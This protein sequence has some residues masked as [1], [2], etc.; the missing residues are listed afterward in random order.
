[1]VEE[2]LEKFKLKLIRRQN[3]GIQIT[4]LEEDWRKAVIELLY[5]YEKDL[6]LKDRV[7]ADSILPHE[8]RLDLEN[9]LKLKKM[10]PYVEVQ[11]IESIIADAENLFDFFLP[12]LTLDF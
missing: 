7:W 5:I 1:M 2:W 6:Q 11:K 4:G 8:S 12:R 10:F 3:K 9:Y